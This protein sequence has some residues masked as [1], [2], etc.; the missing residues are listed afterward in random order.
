MAKWAAGSDCDALAASWP[1][2]QRGLRGGP[3]SRAK[4]G[5]RG[6][7][8]KGATK[9]KSGGKKPVV[10]SKA[11]VVTGGC[12]KQ[13]HIIPSVEFDGEHFVKATP[14]ENW[15]CKAASGKCR[16][17]APLSRTQ[18][19]SE[20]RD[21][22]AKGDQ[23][24]APAGSPGGVGAADCMSGLGLDDDM[25]GLGLDHCVKASVPALGMSGGMDN[26]GLDG[27]AIP[28]SSA[29]AGTKPDKAGGSTRGRCMSHLL[30]GQKARKQAAK[31]GK[32]NVPPRVLTVALPLQLQRAGVTSIRLLTR[33]PRG[34]NLKTGVLIATEAVPWLVEQVSHEV[35]SGGVHFQPKETALAKPH[36]SFRDKAWVAR[37]KNPA[38]QVERRYFTVS[39]VVDLQDGRKRPASVKE[40][41]QRKDAAFDDA[42]QWQEDW[43]SGL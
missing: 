42:T 38:G 22:L 43:A 14:S 31:K 13:G 25:A 23:I 27:P 30:L 39:A 33:P 9:E 1:S 41:Q 40:L 29:P 12:L 4:G 8:A 6:S 21:L 3:L 24:H 20:L 26:L 19:I 35:T 7:R 15:L 36:F 17:L 37:S 16:S 5:G 28:S 34:A 2:R 32:H 10:C 18:V 11:Y